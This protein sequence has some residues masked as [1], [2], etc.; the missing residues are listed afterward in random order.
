MTNQRNELG[1][2]RGPARA[3]AGGIALL[4]LARCGS[5]QD[6]NSARPPTA[7]AETA[8]AAAT[9]EEDHRPPAGAGRLEIDA[10]DFDFDDNPA[11]LE[12]VVHSRYAYFRFVA[13]PWAQATCD[14]FEENLNLFPMVNLHGD[15]HVEQYA[16]ASEAYGLDDFDRATGG[17]SVI[18]LTRF[19]GSLMLAAELKEWGD[20]GPSL[21]ASFLDGY[22]EALS[23]PDLALTRPSI[24]GRL[25][26]HYDRDAE[27]FLSWAESLMAPIPEAGMPGVEAAVANFGV[28]MCEQDP[29]LRA[30]YFE[31]RRFGS[32]S[33]GIGSG[34]SQKYL[35]RVEGP[36]EAPADDVII[37]FKEVQ[38]GQSTCTVRATSG[39]ML[40]PVIGDARLGRT[41]GRILGFV[42]L[43]PQEEN[44][45]VSFWAKSWEPS[46]HE[47]RLQ[48]IQSIEELREIARDVGH[49]L[50]K[51]HVRQI[52]EPMTPQ[53]RRANRDALDR[54][55]GQI[56]AV[57]EELAGEVTVGWRDLRGQVDRDDAEVSY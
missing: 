41:R 32:L 29:A 38:P 8:S 17:P 14:A 23:D 5:C 12:R 19:G 52:A 25:G 1:H 30:E 3:F 16:V 46:F 40:R 11:V 27:S 33:L 13:L 48:E 36:S 43:A 24:V 21:V 15:A 50:G 37:E 57:S 6:D 39:G 35:A 20:A 42:P 45:G 51:G 44:D 49:Q 9:E 31:L 55:R 54:T 22:R 56:I 4:L 28:L 2:R 18:D 26:N 53:L 47:V 7:A 34:L 10:S